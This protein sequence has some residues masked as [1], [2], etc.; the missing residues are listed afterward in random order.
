M[1]KM[2]LLVHGV[3]IEPRSG[4]SISIYL[5]LI[6]CRF[7]KKMI[8]QILKRRHIRSKVPKA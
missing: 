3:R 6:K 7:R 1:W 5:I 2:G 8:Y 4:L